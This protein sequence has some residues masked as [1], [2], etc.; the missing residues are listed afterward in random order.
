ME[1]VITFRKKFIIR[2]DQKPEDIGR[3]YLESMGFEMVE[4]VTLYDPTYGDDIECECG[5]T[6]YRHFDA[7]DNMAPVGCKY[8]HGHEEGVAH[9]RAGAV[10]DD[11]KTRDWTL[12]D[13]MKVA[14]ICTG[15]KRR[16]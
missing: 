12:E 7:Y 3:S 11:M 13:W 8:C 15:F 4:A 9:R 5:H 10:P 16:R 6:Y 2:E 1:C 14:S